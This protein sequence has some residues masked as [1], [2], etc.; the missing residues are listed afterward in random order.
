MRGSNSGSASESVTDDG[1]VEVRVVCQPEERYSSGEDTESS[2]AES[3]AVDAAEEEPL[4]YTGMG[5]DSLGSASRTGG[6]HVR[7]ASGERAEGIG[8]D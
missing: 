7:A 3:D 5:Y 4:V 6:R 2:W 1:R 8:N